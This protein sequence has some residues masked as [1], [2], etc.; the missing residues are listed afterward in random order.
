[1]QH[2]F[3][4]IKFICNILNLITFIRNKINVFKLISPELILDGRITP[5]LRFLFKE[6]NIDEYINNDNLSQIKEDD[7]SK[8]L[9]EI[10]LQCKILGIPKIFNICLFNNINGLTYISIGDL[11]LESFN[12]FFDDYKKNIDK[13]RS[14]LTLKIGL[15]NTIL[16]YEE[17]ED[18]IKEFINIK[19][20]NLKTKVLFSFLELKNIEQINELRECVLHSKTEKLVVQIGQNN[21]ILLNT[22]E[23]IDNEKYKI[24]LEALYYTMTTN[25]YNILIKDKIIKKLKSYFKKNKEKVVVCKPYSSVFDI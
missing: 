11:D 10:T 18:K 19:P 23:H 1:M 7:C 4:P 12:G 3:R 6:F 16:S 17:I 14:L 20:I 2:K 8:S 22:C 21:K 15:N 25:S 13:M 9:R 5:C 24:E